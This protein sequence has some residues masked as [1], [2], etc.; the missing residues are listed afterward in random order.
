VEDPPERPA[1]GRRLQINAT[2]DSSANL[3][4]AGFKT[5]VQAAIQ[6][7]DTTFSNNIVINIAFGWG[8]VGGQTMN[9]GAIG[10]SLANYDTGYSYSQVKSALLNA[11]A[12]SSVLFQAVQ[13][14]P[15]IDP[16]GGA[17]FVIT[18]AEEKALGLISGFSSAVDGYVGLSSTAAF[19]FDPNNRAVAG[20]Y[21]AIGTLE[22]EISEVL[23]RTVFTG[24]LSSHGAHLDDPLDLFRFSAP[25]VHTFT[26]G[27]ASFS[28][29]NGVTTLQTFNN[30]ANGGD[31]GDWASS[32]Q[33]D[34]FDAFAG[35]GV[36]EPVSLADV[37]EMALLG[38]A[39]SS[40]APIVNG[41]TVGPGIGGTPHTGSGAINGTSGSDWLLGGSGNDTLHGGGGSDYLDG[42]A[43]LNTALYDGVWRQYTVAVGAPTTVSGGPEGG[44][45]ELVNIQR[46]QFVDGYVATSPTDTAGQVYR[47]YEATLARAPDQEGLTNW[48]NA[49]NGGTSLQSVAAGFVGSQEFQNTYGALDNNRFVTLL[50]ENVLHR[51]PDQAGL[52]SWVGML[53]TGQD[54]RAQVVL[55]FSE[56]PE[57]INDLTAPVQ[58]G[59]WVGNA[60]AAEVA[61]L[62]DTVLGRLPDLTGL[63]NWTQSL[64]TGASL[65]QVTQGFVASAEFQNTYGALD[66]TGFVTLLYSNVL[67]RPPDQAGETNWVNMLSSGQDT[68]AQVVMAF[69]ESQEHIANT[70]AHIDSGIWIAG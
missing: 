42:G 47:L 1:E 41:P 66:N 46:I 63:A 69:S 25:N 38:Y 19:A 39:V 68:R 49:L 12:G 23:G 8:E 20:A 67:H 10:E 54:T 65:L 58:Q 40:T 51:P 37:E 26:Q 60:D 18:T 4:P 64:E 61:R 30:A 34:A 28:L 53:N 11:D 43:G 50:Y 45:D 35:R 70:A 44:A 59:L 17:R 33:V 5:A 27:Y 15:V 2:Y 13:D 9:S 55:G 7:F 14:L 24:Q 32:N 3:A 52:S 48:T 36:L 6:F 16:T 31:A 57:D 29:D 62:Y 22:H 56:S 21:D